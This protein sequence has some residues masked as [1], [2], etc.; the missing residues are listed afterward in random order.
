M[1]AIL[2]IAWPGKAVA[3][4]DEAM[5]EKEPGVPC[6][7]LKRVKGAARKVRANFSGNLLIATSGLYQASSDF[8]CEALGAETIEDAVTR[9]FRSKRE[10]EAGPRT[11]ESELYGGKYPVRTILASAG[12][13]MVYLDYADPRTDELCLEWI[14]ALLPA[15]KSGSQ[16]GL[17]SLLERIEMETVLHPVDAE[18]NGYAACIGGCAGKHAGELRAF[19][20]PPEERIRLSDLPGTISYLGGACAEISLTIG[21]NAVGLPALVGITGDPAKG[22]VIRYED[23]LREP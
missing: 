1:T 6:C 8:A 22:N 11:A 7:A 15:G 10:Y 17:P 21:C 14:E 5:S 2:A 23:S 20:W 13:K 3:L 4:A 16:A 18:G 19:S 12:G 9:Y